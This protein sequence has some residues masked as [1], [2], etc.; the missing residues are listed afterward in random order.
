MKVTVNNLMNCAASTCEALQQKMDMYRI[1]IDTNFCYGRFGFHVY[2]NNLDG[3]LYRFYD[4]Y[5]GT[6]SETFSRLTSLYYQILVECLH[7][8]TE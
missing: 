7:E 4:T 2:I 1:K 6:K 3:T 5:S 8:R